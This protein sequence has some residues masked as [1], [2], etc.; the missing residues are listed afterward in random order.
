MG[1]LRTDLIFDSGDRGPGTTRELSLI[2]RR[3]TPAQQGR[4]GGVTPYFAQ[5][6]GLVIVVVQGQEG[7][8]DWHP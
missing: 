6:P 7:M 8:M 1:R 3:G 2:F 5:F 4:G